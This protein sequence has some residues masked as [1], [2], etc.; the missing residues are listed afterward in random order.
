MSFR[1]LISQCHDR[2]VNSSAPPLSE[3]GIECIA[4]VYT[5]FRL[6]ILSYQ[7]RVVTGSVR[8][9]RILH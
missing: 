1:Q 5:D 7:C 6:L 2:V 9:S 3:I 4:T 8:L